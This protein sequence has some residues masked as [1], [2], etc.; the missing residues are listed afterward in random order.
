[1]EKNGHGT[2]DLKKA[3]YQSCD[4]FFYELSNKMGINNIFKSMNQFGFGKRTG[5]DIYGE[6]E[7]LLP[8]KDWK[9][10]R[11]NQVWYPGDTIS[12]GIGQG[13]FLATPIQLAVATSIIANKGIRVVPRLL[14]SN[15]NSPINLISNFNSD[16]YL[17]NIDYI[18][19]SM[20]AV[21]SSDG[22]AYSGTES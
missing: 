14:L 21:T 11:F 20:V 19:E 7:G 8:S 22:T 2:V 10:R 13:Y 5:I 17:S 16:S 4:V 9:K 3:I 18:K 15:T 1:M 12:V 6:V